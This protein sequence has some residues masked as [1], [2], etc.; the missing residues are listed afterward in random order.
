MPFN[1]PDEL[2]FSFVLLAD[3]LVQ[4]K[5]FM[6]FKHMEVVVVEYKIEIFI[7]QWHMILGNIL[8]GMPL[9]GGITNPGFTSKVK[10][11]TME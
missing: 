8:E 1:E 5:L 10:E 4:G 7:W 11:P 2:D 9:I 3:I 6:H